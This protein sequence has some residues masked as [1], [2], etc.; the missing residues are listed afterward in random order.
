M[1]TAVIAFGG[2]AFV[3][4]GASG[5]YDV[6]VEVLEMDSV[7]A[8]VDA[9]VVVIAGGGVTLPR[10]DDGLHGVDAVIDK[11]RVAAHLATGLGAELLVLVTGVPAVAID[12]DT[13]AQR[14]IDEMT[15]AQARAHLADGQFPVGSMGPKVESTT[16]FVGRGAR[17]ALITSDP[18]VG[19]AL[20]GRHGT[21]VVDD[22]ER[23]QDEIAA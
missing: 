12:Y 3:P 14:S 18:H 19:D 6:P 10:S 1:P 11:D 23:G 16:E 8:L 5:A 17:L 15:V 21:R 2:N 22:V 20:D 9:G 4:E 7:R 13:P